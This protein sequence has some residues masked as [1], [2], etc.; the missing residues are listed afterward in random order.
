M[1]HVPAGIPSDSEATPVVAGLAG[2]HD[3][4][5]FTNNYGLGRP[6]GAGGY[7]G[8]YSMG[9]N[10][11]AQGGYTAAQGGHNAAQGAGGYAGPQNIG[12][13]AAAQ[14]AVSRGAMHSAGGYA[15]A[16]QGDACTGPQGM[17]RWS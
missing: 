10:A 16:Q 17:G 11:A 5:D 8:A 1:V 7:T 14:G 9:F 6:Q 3:G 4:G 2:G 15:V 13:Y 12:G